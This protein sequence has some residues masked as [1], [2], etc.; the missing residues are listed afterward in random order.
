MEKEGIIKFQ[1]DLEEN[2]PPVDLRH[3]RRLNRWR[4]ALFNANLIGQDPQRYNGAGFGNVSQR[5]DSAGRFIITASQTGGIPKL[6]INEHYV[7][8]TTYD[9]ERNAVSASGPI[10]PSSETMTHASVYDCDHA[11]QA[12][13]HAHS[14]VIWEA[15]DQ[16][17]ILATGI[18]AGYGTP[19]MAREVKRLFNESDVRQRGIFSMLGHRDGIVTFGTSVDEAGRL[20]FK[21]LDKAR[22]L[23]TA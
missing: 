17:D 15:A 8:V 7:V 18:Y 12:V 3:I 14:P 11:I 19:D 5:L 23:L 10:P 16:L 20:M 1:Y 6:V 21:Y 13:F 2:R 4:G 22:L 9:L